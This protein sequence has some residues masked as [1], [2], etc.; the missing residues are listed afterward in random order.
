MKALL[1]FKDLDDEIVEQ[2]CPCRDDIKGSLRSFQ[3][4]LLQVLIYHSFLKMRII[5][6]LCFAFTAV[7]A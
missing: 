4:E 5:T 7:V 3:E 6:F 1:S 2:T